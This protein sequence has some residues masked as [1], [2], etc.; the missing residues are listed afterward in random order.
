MT[1]PNPAQFID[2]NNHHL[3]S[4]PVTLEAGT[5]NHPTDGLLGVATIRTPSTTLSA[6]LSPDMLTEWIDL[7]TAL[8]DGMGG[9]SKLQP[10]NMGDVAALNA[11]RKL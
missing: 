9:G 5:I 2:P 10:A 1:T 3:A 6:V 7:L 4:C 8:R 11:L